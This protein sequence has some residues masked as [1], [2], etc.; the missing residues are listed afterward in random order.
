ML[1][2]KLD[3]TGNDFLVADAPGPL[4][5]DVAALCDRHRGVGA[6]GLMIL[7]PG[8]DDVDCTMTLFNADGGLAEMSG[9]GIRCLAW[10]AARFARAKL[11]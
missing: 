5:A 1:L 3:A 4:P 7:G 9:N 2:R 8:D 11:Y 10:V 6:D